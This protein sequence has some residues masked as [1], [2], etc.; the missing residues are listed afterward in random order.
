MWKNT[1]KIELLSDLCSSSGESLNAQ[2]DIDVCYDDYGL[3]YIPGKRIK[4]LMR[5]S[6]E[7]LADI[8]LIDEK[9]LNI[10]F[11]EADHKA[12]WVDFASAE[13][14][15]SNSWKRAIDLL[16]EQG[17][18]L[19]NE[20]QEGQEGR[21][22]LLAAVAEMTHH[23]SVLSQF[24]SV[25]SQTSVDE[26]GVA[27]DGSLRTMRAVNSGQKFSCP[28][29]IRM[30]EDPQGAT[31]ASDEGAGSALVD[32]FKEALRRSALNLRHMGV[33]RTRGLGRVACRIGSEMWEEVKPTEPSLSDNSGDQKASSAPAILNY[34]LHLEQP[35]ILQTAESAGN[36]SDIFIDGSRIMGMCLSEA[37]RSDRELLREILNDESLIFSFAYVSDGEKR[38]LPMPLTM[39]RVKDARGEERGKIFNLISRLKDTGLNHAQEDWSQTKLSGFDATFFNGG[40]TISESTIETLSVDKQINYHHKRSEDKSVGRAGDEGFY[41]LEALKAGQYFAGRI[42]GPRSLLERI[43]ALL[44]DKK[45]KLGASKTAEYGRVAYREISI[46]ELPMEES[47]AVKNVEPACLDSEPRQYVLLLH[48]PLIMYNDRAMPMAEPNVLKQYLS[49]AFT[50]DEKENGCDNIQIEHIYSKIGAIG[51]YQR[52]WS[53]NKPVLPTYVGGSAFVISFK[54]PVALDCGPNRICYLGERTK[55]GYGEYSLHPIDE[56]FA[57]VKTMR[58]ADLRDVFQQ[59]DDSVV[60]VDPYISMLQD[61]LLR[62]ADRLGREKSKS[63]SLTRASAAGRVTLM[64]KESETYEAFKTVVGKIKTDAVRKTAMLWIGIEAFDDSVRKLSHAFGELLPDTMVASEDFEDLVLTADF[65]E[66]LRTNYLDSYLTNIRLRIRKKNQATNK[67]AN[68]DIA[69]QGE[70]V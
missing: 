27:D 18:E 64:L 39:L 42:Q 1:I 17:A 29:R 31:H 21:E 49:S 13:L 20:V 25:R 10:I 33:S 46:E 32:Q 38:F 23:Q 24:T 63:A 67:G 36:K 47:I 70:S 6:A 11:G 30:G 19:R 60:S 52:S 2:I 8:G 68:K 5:E 26:Y 9:I 16:I 66:K 53:L 4:G 43:S 51:G 40:I 48:T 45:L 57:W 41:Q 62:Y 34:V 3:P 54:E 44:K 12:G 28:I 15:D 35:C 55:E 61:Y 14:E 69:T 50:C 37:R 56:F 58:N 59:A 22:E 7:E 65:V